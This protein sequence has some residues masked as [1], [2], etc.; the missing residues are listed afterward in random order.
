MTRPRVLWVM[1][2]PTI[3]SALGAGKNRGFTLR[4]PWRVHLPMPVNRFFSPFQ[5]AQCG[6]TARS[7]MSRLFQLCRSILIRYSKDIVARVFI[8]ARV[9]GRCGLEAHFFV[10]TMRGSQSFVAG[11]ANASVA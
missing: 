8:A 3:G 9:P 11:Q 1:I 7:G 4:S 2:I 6:H 5:P 10:E